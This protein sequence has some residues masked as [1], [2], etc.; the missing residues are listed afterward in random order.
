MSLPIL[1]IKINR[2]PEATLIRIWILTLFPEYFTP[3]I[4]CGV[5]RRAFFNDDLKNTKAQFELKLVNIRDYALNQYK[6]VDDYPFGGAPGMVMRPDVLQN[7]LLKGVVEAGNYSR[8]HFKNDLRIVFPSPR[9]QKWN[10]DL[11][12]SFAKET[13]EGKKDLVFICGRYEGID[14][15]F[16][17][18]H[19]DVE[20]SLGDFVLTGGE[21]PAMAIL[22]SFVRQTPG[23]L[24]NQ[25]GLNE[26]S[27]QN[28]LLEPPQYTRPRVF[29]GEDVPSIYLSGHHKEMEKFKL[30]EA[31]KLTKRLRPD[32]L[33]SKRIKNNE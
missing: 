33:E 10:H 6:S 1:K 9:G 27:F 4:N 23:I 30:A 24:G 22:D 17:N 2:N 21:I 3:L 25:E 15:R 32:L 14:E 13:L 7:A 12:Q 29:D 18:K 31:I 28:D 5:L 19:V 16:I 11:C 26:E 8:D 20:Y